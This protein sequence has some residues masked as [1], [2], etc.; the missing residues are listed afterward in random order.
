M[1]TDLNNSLSSVG[2]KLILSE[3]FY[4]LLLLSLDKHWSRSLPTAGVS[5]ENLH[6]RLSINPE[7]WEGLTADHR[8]GILKHELLH[9]ALQHLSLRSKYP[10]KKLFNIAADLEINQYIERRLLPG[11]NYPDKQSW[12]NVVR[13]DVKAITK[14]YE[15]GNLTKEEASKKF[16]AIPKRGVF[17]EDFAELNLDAKAG[18]DYYYTKLKESMDENGKSSCQN[19]N[20]LMGNGQGEGE[21]Q[22]Q[23]GEGDGDGSGNGQC[24]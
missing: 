22:G 12:E 5:H 11:G 15:A 2:K 21:G 7:F 4:G 1:T 17:L 3:P 19:L 18:T 16:N 13:A 8:L 20:D 6:P 14:D 9:I 10:D 24:D 23:P